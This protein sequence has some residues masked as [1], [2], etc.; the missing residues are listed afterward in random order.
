[1]VLLQFQVV[2]DPDEYG[3]GDLVE[4]RSATN[5][6]G[7]W[8]PLDALPALAVGC[9]RLEDPGEEAASP[10]FLR[11]AARLLASA[12]LLRR[13]GELRLAGS[14]SGRTFTAFYRALKALMWLLEDAMYIAVRL[15]RCLADSLTR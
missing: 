4:P 10:H 8:A 1:M 6:T 15:T 11:L 5:P 3:T 13:S 2:G 14:G 7:I 9:Q 12:R